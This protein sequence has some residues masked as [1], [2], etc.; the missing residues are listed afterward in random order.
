MGKEIVIK[1]R[2]ITISFVKNYK[3]EKINSRQ[4]Q[5]KKTNKIS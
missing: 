3:N 1:G 5:I 4:G 2:G